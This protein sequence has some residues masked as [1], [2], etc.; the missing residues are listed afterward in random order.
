[1]RP[2][3]A[4]GFIGQ[5][6]P[7]QIPCGNDRKKSKSKSFAVFRM[8][9]FIRVSAGKCRFLLGKLRGMTNKGR[10]KHV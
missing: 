8:T 3:N 6:C 4:T 5:V 7:Q 10:G 2:W 1:V 9:S